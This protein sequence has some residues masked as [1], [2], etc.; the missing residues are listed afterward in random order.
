MPSTFANI[1]R[2]L[3]L[4]ILTIF[5]MLLPVLYLVAAPQS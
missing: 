4:K 1:T 2:L 5:S 3:L